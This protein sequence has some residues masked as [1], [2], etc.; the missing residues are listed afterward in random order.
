MLNDC[1]ND[2]RK[3]VVKYKFQRKEAGTDVDQMFDSSN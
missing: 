3:A 2:M 1:E